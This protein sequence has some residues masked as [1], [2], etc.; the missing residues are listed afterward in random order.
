MK[1]NGNKHVVIVDGYSTGRELVRELSSRGATCLHLRSRPEI[2]VM[3]PTCLDLSAYD[4]DL[5]YLGPVDAAIERLRLMHPD[6]VVAGSE[7]GVTFAEFVAHGLGLPSNRVETISTRRNKFEMVE[8]VR[9]RGLRAADQALVQTALQAQAWAKRHGKWPVVVKPMLSAG[10]DG[11]VI[12]NRHAD[13]DHAFAQSLYRENLLGCFND[14]LMIQSYLSGPQFIVNTVSRGGRHFVSDAWEVAY[15]TVPRG[16]IVVGSMRLLDPSQ[17]VSRELIAYTLAVLPALGIENGAAHTELRMTPQGPALIETDACVMSEAMDAAPYRAAGL[18]TQAGR[19]AD[20]LMTSDAV[21]YSAAGESC[22]GFK[23][24][25]TKVFFVFDQ[26]GT[27]RDA[28]GLSRL[29]ALASFCGHYRSLEE[30]A[31]VGRTL[32]SLCCGGVVYLVHD[33]PRQIE[34]DLRQLREWE[35]E[36]ELYAV[37]PVASE[38]SSVS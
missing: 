16:S 1:F 22:Y 23:R 12:C 25:L 27:V 5:G 19:Y 26:P 11:V 9:A 8:A 37:S 2:P 36:G 3:A 31:R 32:G 35:A 20:V 10:S 17:S 38:E 14:R 24:H 30:G 7:W 18:P 15:R 34:A 4:K 13:I 21:N 28:G 33:D 29:K 6:A